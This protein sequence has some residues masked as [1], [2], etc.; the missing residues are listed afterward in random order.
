[1]SPPLSRAHRKCLESG[2]SP[3]EIRGPELDGDEFS[4]CKPRWVIYWSFKHAACSTAIL[5]SQLRSLIVGWLERKHAAKQKKNFCPVC[6]QQ[7]FSS[8]ENMVVASRLHTNRQRPSVPALFQSIGRWFVLCQFSCSFFLTDEIQLLCILCK[9]E[10]S[11]MWLL[12]PWRS[13]R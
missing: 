6:S 8:R 1:M 11:I 13:L 4:P 5:T 12:S 7:P 3:F 9:G 2:W 10:S